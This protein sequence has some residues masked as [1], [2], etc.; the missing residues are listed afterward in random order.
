MGRDGQTDMIFSY[1]LI[2]FISC[3]EGINILHEERDAVTCAI[4]TDS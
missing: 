4:L 2:L 3:I 1:A